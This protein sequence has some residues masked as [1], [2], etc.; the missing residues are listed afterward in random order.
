MILQ[1]PAA[2][3]SA[4]LPSAYGGFIPVEHM[5]LHYTR[6]APDVRFLG[7]HTRATCGHVLKRRAG[8]RPKEGVLPCGL[9]ASRIRPRGDG[10]T[11]PQV[12]DSSATNFGP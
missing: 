9:R 12:F 2:R 7:C 6:P 3:N 4:A 5:I 10:W 11:L 1:Y 8:V